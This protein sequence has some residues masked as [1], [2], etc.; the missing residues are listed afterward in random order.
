MSLEE[1]DRDNWINRLAL[2]LPALAEVQEPYLQDYWRHNPRTHTIVDGRD[3]THFPLND[4]RMVYERSR[5]SPRF[6]EEA[7]YASLRTALDN[8]RHSLPA[9][10]T[11]ERVTITGRVI[12]D[13]DFWMRILNSGSSIS[14]GD[15]I[16]G[17][18]ARA[19]ELSDDRFRKAARELNAFLSPV[20]DGKAAGVLGNFDEGCDAVLFYGLTVAERIEVAEGIAILPFEQARRFVDMDLVEKLAPNGAAFHG[21]RSVGAMVRPFRWRPAFNKR[22]SVNEP[23]PGPSGPFFSEAGIFLDLLAVSHAAPA[24]PLAT[25]SDRIDR[26]AGLL[27][28][29]GSRSPGFYQS[30]PAQGFDGLTECPMLEAEAFEEAREAFDNRESANFESFRPFVG[31]LAAALSRKG[32]FAGDARVLEIEVALEGM[33]ELPEGPLSRAL[34]NR[35]SEFL[36]TDAE[37]RDRIKESV[38]TFYDARSN[39]AHNRSARMTPFTN[40]AAFMTGFDLA[41]QSL[42]AGTR[43]SPGGLGQAVGCGRPTH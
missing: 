3:E 4:V 11:L 29:Q 28:G 31:R 36:G 33:Y 7:Y 8:V 2:I 21:W 37:S 17:L 40:G 23:M 15:L 5:Y 16:A 1:F 41:R 43:R 39:V 14:A 34:R 19:A 38:K 13:N 12:G 30:W 25:L 26:S 20:G 10:P 6:G 27:L 32:R 42:Q 24:V 22:G 18:M 35:V 9:H